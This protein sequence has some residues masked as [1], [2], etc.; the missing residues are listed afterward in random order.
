MLLKIE[1]II[2]A[3]FTGVF[4]VFIAACYGPAANFG[5]PDSF[6]GIVRDPAGNPIPDILVRCMD[7]EDEVASTYTM[8]GDGAFQLPGLYD[9]P[10]ETL[11]FE[12]VDGEENGGTFAPK[13]IELDGV[14]YFEVTLELAE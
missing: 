7:G 9:D 2:L 13:S 10:C 3:L 5:P 4:P 14:E 8:A 11:I 1:K 12:D 6:E